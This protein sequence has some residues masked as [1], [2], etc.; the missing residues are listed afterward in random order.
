VITE[1]DLAHWRRVVPWSTDEQV[2]QDLVLSRLIIEIANH[3]LLGDELVFQG[4]TCLHK[5]WLDRPWRYSED[6]DYVRRTGG[7]VGRIL[8]A[9]R[10]VAETVGFERV[11]T[12]VRRHPKARLDTTFVGG[13]RMRV[14]VEMN[15]FERSPAQPIGTRP[16]KIE[17]PWF[18]GSAD[19]QTFTLEELIATKIR[20]LYQRRKGRD[21]FDMWL[22]IEHGGI[23]PAG[24]AECFGPYRP[25]RWT[26]ELAL[27][28]L[29][30]KVPD[31][32]F[33]TDLSALV[34]D[35]P[36]R[37]TID[38]GAEVARRVIEAASD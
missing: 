35:W 29:A 5:L 17:S 20:A 27:D 22:A 37:Y 1:A 33:T 31:E 12:D 23:S 25:D 4:G 32:R 16:I 15:T 14:R 28:N 13:T 36:E 38:V 24:V 26:P 21:L 2:E 30:R 10:D 8:D 11:Q 18:S 9:L 34:S 19:I 7:G 3:P 6:L